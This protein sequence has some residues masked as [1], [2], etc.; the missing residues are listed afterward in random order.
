MKYFAF[1]AAEDVETV[2]KVDSF[3]KFGFAG[4]VVWFGGVLGTLDGREVGFE[5]GADLYEH[6]H[7]WVVRSYEE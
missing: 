3:E 1:D 6:I 2:D 4:I 7:K 5:E